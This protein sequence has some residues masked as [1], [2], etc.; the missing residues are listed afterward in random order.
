MYRAKLKSFNM[1]RCPECQSRIYFGTSSGQAP[2]AKRIF[3]GG[4]ARSMIEKSFAL[5]KGLIL[6]YKNQASSLLSMRMNFV[7]YD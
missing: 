4:A 2:P 7:N 3:G 5:Y 1:N 6:K